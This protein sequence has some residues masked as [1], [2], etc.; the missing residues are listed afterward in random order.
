MHDIV[1]YMA[2]NVNVSPN[3]RANKQASRAT[4]TN[5]ANPLL[6]PRA[7]D[8][9]RTALEELGEGAVGSHVGVSALSANVATHRFSAHLP[10]YPGWEWQAVLACASGSRHVTVN[11]VALVPAADA[12]RAPEWV[13]WS[14]RIRPGDL[15]PGDLLPPAPDDDRLADGELTDK[16]LA[17]A[18]VRWR[19]GEFGPNSPMAAKAAMQCKTC[20]FFLPFEAG[21]GVCV[22]EYSADGRVVHSRYGC[23]AHSQT[24]SAEREAEPNGTPYD[25][26]AY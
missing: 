7:V 12:L 17:D 9:A 15:G 26:E 13:P 14:K 2:H 23:G 10:G 1:P 6:G 3:K 4:R 20:A 22:N 11:E 5:P 25:D 8:T 24:R 16:A 21:F 18:H 19:T